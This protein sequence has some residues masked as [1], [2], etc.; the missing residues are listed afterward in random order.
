MQCHATIGEKPRAR[1]LE[2]RTVALMPILPHPHAHGDDTLGARRRVGGEE[3][4]G[5]YSL[6]G[7]SD[8]H[9]LL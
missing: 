2:Q 5:D 4:G 9:M 6:G 7:K 1:L 3:R 8:C